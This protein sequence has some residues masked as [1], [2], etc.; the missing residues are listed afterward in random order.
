MKFL[1]DKDKQLL[2]YIDSKPYQKYTVLD[3]YPTTDDQSGTER[4]EI[5]NELQD[6]LERMVDNGDILVECRY[7][8]KHAKF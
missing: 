6:R 4:W 3:L 5:Q 8:S 1:D 7:Y 2:A